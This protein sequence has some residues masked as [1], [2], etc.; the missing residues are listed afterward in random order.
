MITD[1]VLQRLQTQYQIKQYWGGREDKFLDLVEI[2][3]GQQLSIRSAKAIFDRFLGF[4]STPARRIGGP[5]ALLDT[6]DEKLRSLGYSTPKIRYLKN[7]SLSL[8]NGQL[9]LD[10]VDQLSDDEIKKQL[11]QIKGIGPWTIEMF[12]IF[13]LNRP[14]V[15]SLGDLGLRTAIEKLYGINRNDK[16]KILELS[17]TWSPQRTLASRLL[18]SSLGDV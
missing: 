6:P 4:Y 5:A 13:S 2:I 16:Q 14:D 12:L 15:F 3:T 11:I 17:R 1:P 7:L 10:T 9:N 18:W 8:A